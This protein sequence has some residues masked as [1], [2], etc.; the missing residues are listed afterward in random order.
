MFLSGD[1]GSVAQY[2]RRNNSEDDGW[3]TVYFWMYGLLGVVGQWSGWQLSKIQSTVPSNIYKSHSKQ[4]STINFYCYAYG[5]FH[6]VIGLHHLRWSFDK[7]YGKL[8]L[9][10]YDLPGIYEWTLLTA[11]GCIYEAMMI[12]AWPN[13]KQQSSIATVRKRKAVLDTVSVTTLFSFV[14]FVVCNAV[15]VPTSFAVETKLW[16]VTMY[17]LPIV[18]ALGWAGM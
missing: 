1:D 6:L 16:A 15:G 13:N 8:E 17:G 2:P 9:W 11:V 18:L 7:S 4:Q 5:L 10:R 14:V 12:L 3:N